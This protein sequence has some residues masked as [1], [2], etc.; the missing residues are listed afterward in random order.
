[1]NDLIAELYKCQSLENAINK[2]IG[3]LRLCGT[4]KALA[5][6]NLWRQYLT[7]M[8]DTAYLEEIIALCDGFFEFLRNKYP[9]LHFSLEGRRKSILSTENK[10]QRYLNLGKSL[11]HIQDFFAFRIIIDNGNDSIK[12]CYQ[13]AQDLIEYALSNEFNPSAAP[14]RIG[15]IYQYVPCNPFHAMFPYKDNIKDYIAYPKLNGYQSIHIVFKDDCGR[16]VEWQIRTLAQHQVA[17]S[18]DADHVTYKAQTQLIQYDPSKI[19]THGYLYIEVHG[20]ESLIDIN[21]IEKPQV[22]YLKKSS[23]NS[24]SP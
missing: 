5:H 9:Q 22:I 14:P 19:Q 6:A 13:V 3:A 23:Q 8:H 16:T 7:R 17:E 4:P 18:G 2:Y 1:M 15:T 10:I 12:T 24:P 11:D 20:H 21:G